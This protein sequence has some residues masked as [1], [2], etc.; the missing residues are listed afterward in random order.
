MNFEA[1]RRALTEELKG[2]GVSDE[3]VLQAIAEIPR[4]SFVL[5]EYR[6]AAYDDRALPIAA[7]QTI[8]QPLMVALMTQELRLRGDERILEI[9]TGSGY[10]A[11]ILAKLCRQVISVERIAELSRQAQRVL[12]QLGIRNVEC[13]VGDGTLGWAVGAPY[14][15]IIVTAGAPEVPPALLDQLALNGR[16]VIPV[17]TES[18]VMLQ[19]IIKRATGR[20]VINVCACSFVP[21]IGEQAWPEK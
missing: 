21:L 3:R 19:T 10:Q 8:S 7:A 9:G 2:R 16:L 15:G 12:E 18:P 14:D 13:H 20:E 17:G 6:E 5:P 1:Q 11:A 4:E